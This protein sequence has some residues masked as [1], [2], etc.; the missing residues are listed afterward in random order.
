MLAQLVFPYNYFSPI[1][2]QIANKR[3]ALLEE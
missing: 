3:D 1:F 2:R